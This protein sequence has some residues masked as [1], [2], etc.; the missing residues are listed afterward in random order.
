MNDKGQS[1]SKKESTARATESIDSKIQQQEKKS[2]QENSKE[3]EKNRSK[4]EWQI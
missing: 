1:E 2:F 4:F 3:A